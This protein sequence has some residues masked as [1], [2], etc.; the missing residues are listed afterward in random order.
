MVD[1]W[2]E[3]FP[4]EV[5]SRFIELLLAPA[6]N[7][8]MIW[9]V[10]PLLVSTFLMTIYFGKYRKEELGWNTAFGKNGN[11]GFTCDLGVIFQGSPSADFSTNGTLANDANFLANLAEEEK[12]LE[13]EL[14]NFQYYPVIAI[15]ISYRF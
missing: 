8:D 11:W 13:D 12:N 14:E 1:Y 6:N 2:T 3:I 10:I 5:V 4:N 9:M 15:G 7:I